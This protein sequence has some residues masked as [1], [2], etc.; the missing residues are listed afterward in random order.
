[1]LGLPSPMKT[2]SDNFSRK[3]KPVNK[4]ARVCVASRSL[5]ERDTWSQLREYESTCHS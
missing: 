4:S 5:P 3:L 2:S 1:M